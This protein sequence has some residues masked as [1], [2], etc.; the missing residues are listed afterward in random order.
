MFEPDQLSSRRVFLGRSALASA[1]VLALGTL[2]L[3]A[4]PARAL[5]LSSGDGQLLAFLERLQAL[6]SE[7]S[8]RAMLGNTT[9]GLREGEGTVLSLIGQQDGEQ[10]R[11]CKLAQNRFGLMPN[12][13]PSTKS[14]GIPRNNFEFSESPTRGTLLRRALSLKTTAAGVWTGAVSDT[15]RGELASAL[16]SLAGVQN[17]HRAILADFLGEGALV[18]YAP[19][20][21]L[22]QGR[23]QLARYG[24]E[25]GE[26]V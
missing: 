7:F 8:M 15:N 24:F 25:I 9:D 10:E 1:G 13:L 17:R 6:Q 16:A 2:S 11:W 21:S 18:A 12:A 14:G 22:T 19:A 26:P 4:L 5:S 20:L 3:P 23:E